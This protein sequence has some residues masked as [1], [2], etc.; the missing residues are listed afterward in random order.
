MKKEDNGQVAKEP[1]DDF[2]I[3]SFI[4]M[5]FLVLSFIAASFYI[6]ISTYL[7]TT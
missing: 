2:H 4:T 1:R 3:G 5:V 7:E 6:L